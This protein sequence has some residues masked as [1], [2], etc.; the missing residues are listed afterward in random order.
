MKNTPSFYTDFFDDQLNTLKAEGRYRTFANIER[1]A[2]DFPNAVLKDG[3]DHKDIIIW[4]SNDYLGMG[5]HQKVLRATLGA[6]EACGAGAGGTRNISGTTK[7][8]VDLEQEL[9]SLHEKEAALIFTSGYVANDATLTTLGSKLP[10]CIIY[11]DAHN[12]ASMIQGI[13]HSGA[14]KRIFRHNDYAHL[15]ELLSQDDPDAAKIVA[16]ESVYSMDGDIAPIA[17]ICA[18]AKDY[19]A[20]TYIDEV[21]GV[22][23]YG[24]EGAGVVQERGLE[25]QIDIM[26]GTLGKA[27]GLVG[28]YIAA[29]NS[30]IDFVRSFA[31][32]FIFT[33]SIAPSVAA[34]CLASIK[35]LR[36]SD[37][38]RRIQQE[39]ATYLKRKLR[40]A[41]IPYMHSESHIVPVMVHDAVKCKQIS[42]LLLTKHNMYAQPINYPTVPIGQER[43]RFTPSAIHTTQMCDDLVDALCAIW[44][45]VDLPLT[46]KKM[47][48]E[49]SQ[50]SN[51]DPITKVAASSSKKPYLKIA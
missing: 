10:N 11:S 39:N 40:S 37:Q 23:M 43:L 26:Q 47:T 12:H 3:S 28:G 35:H 20:L 22:G 21:H 41:G 30:L 9:A 27:F 13:R 2:G 34:G 51:Q 33:T 24:H 32:G 4:C 44:N 42:D 8:H 1:R 19:N 14:Q 16:F 31:S 15:K 38:E 36:Q 17:E 25:D 6:L 48:Q 50:E 29:S 18:V 49:I 45:E 7:Y 46:N 5:Q